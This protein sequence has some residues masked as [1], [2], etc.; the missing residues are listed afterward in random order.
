[1]QKISRSKKW[2]LKLPPSL[3]SSSHFPELPR[4]LCYHVNQ[5]VYVLA[6]SW[7]SHSIHTT[8]LALFYHHPPSRKEARSV[9]HY[10]SCYSSSQHHLCW[11]IEKF[12]L[13]WLTITEFLLSSFMTPKRMKIL[14]STLASFHARYS[15]WK[16]IYVASFISFFGPH[17]LS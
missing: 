5:T 8:N 4:F 13:A 11:Y 16:G 10:Y 17:R 15:I 14:S 3:L 1:M 6:S 9:F 12:L 7:A 2:P